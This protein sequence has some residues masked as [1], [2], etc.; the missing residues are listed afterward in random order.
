MLD[1]KHVQTSSFQ[2][3]RPVS[4]VLSD[5]RAQLTGQN[6]RYFDLSGRM[7]DF[8][9][10][11]TSLKGTGLYIRQNI[12]S[13]INGSAPLQKGAVTFSDTLVISYCDSVQEKMAVSLADTEKNLQIT[14]LNAYV[15]STT[16]TLEAT[17]KMPGSVQDAWK[18]ANGHI[19]LSGGDSVREF[20]AS[21]TLVWGYKAPC[22]GEMHNCQPLPGGKRFFGENCSGKLFISDSLGTAS[23][24]PNIQMKDL[25]NSNNHSRFR[26]VRKYDSLY[27]ITA[28]GENTIYMFNTQGQTL[29]KIDNAKLS[30]FGVTFNAVHSA[31][32]L[33]NG[34]ILIGSG[35]NLCRR[36]PTIAKWQYGL[37]RLSEYSQIFRDNTSKTHCMEIKCR[38]SYR[39]SHAYIHAGCRR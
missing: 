8:K 22:G 36:M 17:Y 2:Q 26:M 7:V 11:G 20:D 13:N 25:G 12:C 29:R 1:N 10:P 14:L 31:I 21:G 23:P 27:L 19:L 28:E 4:L 32:L 38:W 39:K 9:H 30:R 34:N 3:E 15:I 6:I 35:F 5:G 18:L 24:I 37:L 33:P 16:N